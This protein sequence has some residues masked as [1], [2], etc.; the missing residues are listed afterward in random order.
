MTTTPWWREK[1]VV[2]PMTGSDQQGALLQVACLGAKGEVEEI[3]PDSDWSRGYIHHE[4]AERLSV[5]DVP[6]LDVYKL[7]LYI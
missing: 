6:R 2:C 3:W 7:K 4:E 5:V 1:L